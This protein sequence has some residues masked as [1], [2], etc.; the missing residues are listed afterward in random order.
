MPETPET[1]EHLEQ[2]K[3][4]YFGKKHNQQSQKRNSNKIVRSST[5]LSIF[6]HFR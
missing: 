6:R 1:P 3:Q 5:K 4:A 2:T